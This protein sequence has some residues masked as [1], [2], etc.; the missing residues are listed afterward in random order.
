MKGAVYQLKVKGK[1]DIF[2]TYNPE[3]NFIKQVYKRHVNFAIQEY[4]LD[5][6]NYT[7]FG[8]RTEINIPRNGDFL[9]KLHFQFTLPPLVKT[10]G[11]YAGWTNSIGH[12]I[13]DY[14][15]L[16]IGGVLIDKQYGLFMEIWNELTVSYGRE[17][18]MLGKYFNIASLENN[19]NVETTYTVPLKFWFCDNIGASLPLLCMYHSSIKLI[20]NMTEFSKCIIYDGVTP[21]NQVNIVTPRLI[22]EY[23]YL[24]SSEARKYQLNPHKYIISQVQ[25]LEG[26]TVNSGGIHR[27][28]LSFNHPCNEILFIVRENA[29]ELNN[30]WY[31]F[32]IRNTVV[33]TPILPLIKNC[34]L[35]IDGRDHTDTLEENVLRLV[36]ANRF[37]SNSTTKHIYTIPLCNEPE[38][39]YPNGS[40]N[41]SM[42]TLAELYINLSNNINTSK[43]YVFARNY[44]FVTIKNG[45]LILEFC[46]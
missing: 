40:L 4:Y 8:G 27:C 23:V 20:F 25:T 14:I 42:V 37:H 35:V 38:K 31:N 26:E 29:S 18:K 36:H 24:D 32:A 5:F 33:N 10:S 30:D 2:L 15:E 41:F 6:K 44:N 9:S 34:K 1:Q 21:P 3:Y 22:A 46:A 43:I 16:Y 19:A 45:E 17:N 11:T 12:C 39:W 28:L 7:N 13:L